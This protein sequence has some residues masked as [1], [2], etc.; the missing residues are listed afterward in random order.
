MS[1]LLTPAATT[2][3]I[4]PVHSHVE[5]SVR[6]LMIATVRG[7][8]AEVAGTLAGDD[9]DP[10]HATI[11]ITIPAASIDTREPQ[12]DAHLRSADF[13]ETDAH[14]HIVFRSTRVAKAGDGVFRVDGE[15]TIRGTTRPVTLRVE[16]GGRVRDPW[17]GERAA[18]SATTTIN[19]RD[20]GLNWTQLLETGG[21][22]VG[23]EVSISVELE[24]I[25]A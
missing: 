16:S 1:T 19:R 25:K 5:F 24:L 15:L 11:D 9:D 22:L 14:P 20:F 2:W 3:R 21:V 8:F 6:H 17:G 23:D 7:R 13:L 10:D 18:Y 12:R 4:D